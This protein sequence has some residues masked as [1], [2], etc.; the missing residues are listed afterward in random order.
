MVETQLMAVEPALCERLLDRLGLA[1]DAARTACRL[2]NEAPAELEL[3]GLSHA[4]FEW[5]SAYLRAQ[6]AAGDE[7]PAY[8]VTGEEHRDNIVWLSARS[9]DRAT[10][11]HRASI[12]NK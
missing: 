12:G 8:H 2:R 5:I 11:S 10:L 6:G 7:A 1:L 3:R 9:R 4:E